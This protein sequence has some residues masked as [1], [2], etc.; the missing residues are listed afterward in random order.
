[1]WMI[2]MINEHIIYYDMK[3]CENVQKIGLYPMFIFKGPY[4][5]ESDELQF[6]LM[7]AHLALLPHGQTSDLLFLSLD[8]KMQWETQD[9]QTLHGPKRIMNDQ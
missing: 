9:H 4:S 6:T 1:M 3:P 2:N 7:P 8:S 5:R